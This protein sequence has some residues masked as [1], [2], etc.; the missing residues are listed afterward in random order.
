V[1]A[2]FAELDG[3]TALE[4]ALRD[5]S[6]P[7]RRKAA[8]LIASLLAD[9]TTLDTARDAVLHKASGFV[10]QLSASLSSATAQPTGA[11]GDGDGFDEDVAESAVRALRAIGAPQLPAADRKA[12]ADALAAPTP[13]YGLTADERAELLA[14]VR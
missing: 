14:A 8:F 13:E 3:W 9:E 12:L 7:S 2:R 1:L 11:N 6:L 5:P 4:E 10:P